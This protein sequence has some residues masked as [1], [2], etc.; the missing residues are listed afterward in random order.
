MKIG[1]ID[2]GAGNILS[3]KN[4]LIKLGRNFAL[5]ADP[6]VLGT[7]DKLIFPG[8]G[9]AGAAMSAL[10]ARDLQNFIVNFEKPF[11][12]ICLGLQLLADRSEEADTKCLGIL[13]GEVKLFKTGLK[14]PQIGWNRV[15][16]MKESAL[17]DGIV[18]ESN[19]Y[20]VNSYHL[21]TDDEFVL[22]KTL[23]G[24]FFPSIIR[25][26]NFYA[27]QFHPEKSGERGLKLLSN[28][29]ESC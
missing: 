24:C 29:C 10:R 16:F 8:V 6:A 14:V 18:D 15:N 5:S 1:I 17:F 3:V 22:A 26:N 11:L 4:A 20:F 27:T 13:P 7:C 23:Y 19:F 28:F 21:Q 25:K 12:G 2:Y 9:A